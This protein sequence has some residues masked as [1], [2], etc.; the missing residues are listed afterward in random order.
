MPEKPAPQASAAG[1]PDNNAP[2]PPKM[3]LH[4]AALDSLRLFW[5][6]LGLL[7]AANLTWVAA[8]TAPL[9]LE[10]LMPERARPVLRI[11]ALLLSP[12]MIS[13]LT[14]GLFSIARSIERHEETGYGRLWANGIRLARPALMLASI[15]SIITCVLLT[16][17]FFYS[18]VPIWPARIAGLIACY[19]CLLWSATLPHQWP[20][21]IAQECGDLD[22]PD[23]TA[24]R[25]AAAALRRALFLV[26]GK[27]ITAF[28][29]LLIIALCG[30]ALAASVIAPILGGFALLALFTT[31]VT[32]GL[33]VEYGAVPAPVVEEPVPDELFR[34][35]TQ[36]K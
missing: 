9:S 1:S 23:R 6:R 29:L 3:R 8:A 16:S 15:Q 25:G 30:A 36:A 26:I 21:F 14:A 17:V 4:R 34:I 5:D 10:P 11:A 28:A 27:P 32:R 35:K 13:P 33:F 7:L 18:R 19:A 2:R 24:R 22:D 20:A 31:S 12:I